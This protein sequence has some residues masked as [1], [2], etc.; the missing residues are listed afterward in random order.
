MFRQKWLAP[1]AFAALYLLLVA[2]AGALVVAFRW[3][4]EP[5]TV[6]LIPIF[7]AAIRFPGRL[8]V[9]LSVM[10]ALVTLS[11]DWY[12]GNDWDANRRI[13]AALSVTVLVLGEVI[14]QNS[15]RRR[16]AEAALRRQTAR[17]EIA[18]DIGRTATSTLELETLLRTAVDL[19]RERFALYLVAIFLVEPGAGVAVLREATG[20]IGR[21]LKAQGYQLELEAKSLIGRAVATRRQQVAQDVARNS[22]YLYHALAPATRAEV[23][24]PL[25]SGETVLGVLDVHSTQAERFDSEL[26]ATLMLI[27][28]QLAV[29][30][31]NARLHGVEKERARELEQAYR[32][33]Q[34]SQERLLITEKLAA[35]GRLTAGIARDVN[36]P[37]A[38][39]RAA[40]AR[41][42]QLIAE[43]RASAGDPRVGPEDHRAIAREMQ[44]ALQLGASAAERTADFMRGLKAQTRTPDGRQRVRFNAVSVMQ[45]ALL[46]LGQA[47]HYG[48][49]LATF[50]PATDYI[51]LEGAPELLNQVVTSLV[52][53]AIEAS[54]GR[55]GSPIG[56]RLSLE[57]DQVVLQIKDAGRGVPAEDLPRIFDPLF[58]TKPSGQALGLGLTLV[59]DIVTTKF[60]GTVE[61]ASQ[62][63]Q[64]TTVTLRFPRPPAQET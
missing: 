33:L 28:D 5:L 40:L 39:V 22:D 4:P 32:A 30:I 64:G 38:A 17:L 44:A 26:L 49:C 7:W 63:G 58:T 18:V 14:Y 19:V 55:D 1:L 35:L 42:E 25:L 8:Y 61:V 47:L 62:P 23:V 41:L 20:E 36:T 43:Y 60:D 34:Q 59:H 6:F 10:L 53:N 52:T 50:M 11:V 57:G 12:V 31:Q 21:E 2:G 9:P 37:L 48:G 46:L 16:G 15:S 56:L 24:V 45:Q 54:A 3:P 27:A 29:A 13:V 51:E